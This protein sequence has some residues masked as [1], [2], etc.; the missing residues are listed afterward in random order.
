MHVRMNLL[1]YLPNNNINN[2]DIR[3]V[4]RSVVHAFGDHNLINGVSN[5]ISK[6]RCDSAD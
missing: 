5:S 6:R 2:A 4:A 3:G 1:C